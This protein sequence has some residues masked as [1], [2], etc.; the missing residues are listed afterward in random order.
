[1]KVLK[2]RLKKIIID[3][4]L[5]LPHDRVIVGVSGGPDSVALLCLLCQIEFPLTP[6]AVYIDHGL[7]PKEVIM[8]IQLIEKEIEQKEVLIE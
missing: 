8:E 4:N 6:V 7:R 5:L 3:Q 2:N 1:M